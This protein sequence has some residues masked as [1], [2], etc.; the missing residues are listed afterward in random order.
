MKWLLKILGFRESDTPQPKPAPSDKRSNLP[1]KRTSRIA[2]PEG[3]RDDDGPVHPALSISIET[4]TSKGREA[5]FSSDA[6]RTLWQEIQ[7]LSHPEH[8][9]LDQSYSPSTLMPAADYTSWIAQRLRDDDWK[10]IS[11]FL[12]FFTYGQQ[13]QAIEKTFRD[14]SYSS[15]VSG[16]DQFLFELKAIAIL[17]YRIPWTGHKDSRTHL[18]SEQFLHSMIA[19]RFCLNEDAI[20]NLQRGANNLIRRQNKESKEYGGTFIQ[21]T[22][23]IQELRDKKDYFP[24][25]TGTRLSSFPVTFR[26][27]I[28]YS[29]ERGSPVP[30]TIRPQLQ[31]DYGLRQYG[32]SAIQNTRYFDESGI[33]TAPDDLSALASRLQKKEL[34]EIGSKSGVETKKS[35]KKDQILAALLDSSEAKTIIKE[36]ASKELLQVR[37]EF[38]DDFSRW[39]MDLKEMRNIALCLATV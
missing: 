27:C 4:T 32:L 36:K 24:T 5:V 11:E 2:V 8:P 30:G 35:W 9:F 25:Q 37:T 28:G 12:D 3:N 16:S 13:I 33:F 7:P 23:K 34:M 14:Y 6:I 21:E 22:V 15:C 1:P 10:S 29:L 39:S 18:L 31:G 19:H 20:D 38:A 17:C 26:S